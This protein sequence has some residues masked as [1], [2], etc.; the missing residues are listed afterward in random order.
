MKA[1]AIREHGEADCIYIE[2][3]PE[4]EATEHEVLLEV[5]AAALNHLDLW[6]RRGGR[7]RLR[8]PHVL[9]SDAAGVVAQAGPRASG[10]SEGQEVVLNPGLYCGQCEFCRR[11]ENSLCPEYGIIGMVRP[12]T[13][14]EYVCVPDYTLYPK[15]AHLSFEEAAALPLDHLTAWRMLI[16]RAALSPGETVLI[17]G[18]GGGVALAG[19]Q[20]AKL[21]GAEVVVTSSSDEKLHRAHELGADYGVNYRSEQVARRVREITAGR[22]V[23]VIFDSVGAT[24]WETNFATIRRGGRIVH[25]GVT[26]GDRAEVNMQ[27]LYWNQLN[28]LG[29]TMG[30]REEFRRMLEAVSAAKL[31]PVID[32]VHPLEEVADATRRMESGEQFGK[33]VLTIGR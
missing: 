31:K 4:A 24:T 18:I 28:I 17:H 8:M 12:G 32:S 15:P 33:I 13:F 5:K 23:D 16:T 9:G 27:A 3:L 29:S 10:V 25:C 1:A 2:D 7:I 11:G 6:V 30:G 20:I 19:L 22:G 14:A 26:G 21:T